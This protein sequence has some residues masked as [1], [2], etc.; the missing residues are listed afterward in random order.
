M[1]VIDASGIVK[2]VL[3]EEGHKR[4][5]EIFG[6]EL[7]SKERVVTVNLALPE[8]LNAIWKYYALR[9]ELTAS[10]F[11]SAVDDVILIFNRL[12]KVSDN[13]TARYASSLAA[14]HRISVYDAF[15]LAASFLSSSPLLTFDGALKKKAE[16]IGIVTLS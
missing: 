12:E 6:K 14:K 1:T 5:E 2:L 13:E 7:S 9:K 11:E 15:Y 16:Q 3:N 10:E 8:S 4:A